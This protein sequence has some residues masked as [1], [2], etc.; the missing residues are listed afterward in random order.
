[1]SLAANVAG[2]SCAVEVSRMERMLT[3]GV[4][5]VISWDESEASTVAQHE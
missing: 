1:M 2:I 5:C 4:Y 3:S